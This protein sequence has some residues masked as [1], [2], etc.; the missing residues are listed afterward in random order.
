MNFF[1][2]SQM[3]R[4]GMPI[5][6]SISKAY[7]ETTGGG[8]KGKDASFFSQYFNKVMGENNLGAPPLTPST[9]LQILNIEKDP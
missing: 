8:G 1:K 2:V 5:F 4:A 3:I 9:A 7:K 6:K